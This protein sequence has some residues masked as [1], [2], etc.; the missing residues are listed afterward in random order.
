MRGIVGIS[1]SPAA[2]VRPV[3]GRGIIVSPNL[4]NR[5]VVDQ[6]NPE[7][8]PKII[9]VSQCQPELLGADDETTR[10]PI[11]VARTPIMMRVVDGSLKR[12]IPRIGVMSADELERTLVRDPPTDSIPL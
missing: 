1:E 5:F 2:I 11:P 9:P 12:S 6:K 3:I 10:I 4:V 8:R 7:T